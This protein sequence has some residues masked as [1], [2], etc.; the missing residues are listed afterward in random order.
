MNTPKYP[1]VVVHGISDK[2]GDQQSG[3]SRVL[4]EKVMPDQAVRD[5]Y[6]IEAVW[7]PVNNALDD[8]IQDIVLKLVDTYDKTTY[9]RDSELAKATSRMCKACVWVRWVLCKGLAGWFVKKTTRALDLVLDLPMYLGNPKGEKIRAKVK[10]AIGR[11]LDT[12]AEGVVLVGHSLGS[13]IAYDVIR[14]SQSGSGEK[15]PIKAFIT[16]GSPL[17]WVTDLR[18]AEKEVPNSTFNIEGI[19]WVN[20]YDEQDPVPLNTELS[21]SRFPN[22]QNE[23]AICSG[24][25]YI[26]AHTVYW[27]RD[28]IARK[29]ASLCYGGCK[30]V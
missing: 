4:G 12:K 15:F 26:D 22:V 18:I 3:F 25:K 6:W 19:E 23:P 14:E 16:M 17:A 8:K 9:W 2:T 11:A 5:K 13:V 10:E 28:E 21:Q 29:I 30:S 1:V 20:F 27:Q 24:K 7:E